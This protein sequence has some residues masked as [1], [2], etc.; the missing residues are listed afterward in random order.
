MAKFVSRGKFR[1]ILTSLFPYMGTLI[2]LWSVSMEENQYMNLNCESQYKRTQNITQDSFVIYTPLLKID[3]NPRFDYIRYELQTVLLPLP[4]PPP[5]TTC[6]P[7]SLPLPLP[8]PLTLSLSLQLTTEI[9]TATAT[10][11]TTTTTAATAT[12]TLYLSRI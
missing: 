9:A 12:A 8:L 4:L 1:R 10:V 11:T 3:L 7:L 2:I 5:L 6:P